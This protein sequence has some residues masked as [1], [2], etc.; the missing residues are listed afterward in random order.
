VIDNDFEWDDDKADANF[1]KHGVLFELATEIFDD[2]LALTVPDLTHSEDEER[3]VTVG[4]TFFHHVL[5]V[6]HTTRES[7]T[8]IISARRATRS[9]RLRYMEKKDSYIHDA[10]DP[11]DHEIDFSKGVRGKYYNPKNS[12]TTLRRIDFDVSRHFPD[13]DD[14]NAAL[15]A[16][17]AEGK[18]PGPREE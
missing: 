8:R 6:V 9:E 7:R 5:V 14:L 4:S 12:T 11:L 3:E 15:R 13:N 2:P 18:A 10:P 16:L 17:I 1:D